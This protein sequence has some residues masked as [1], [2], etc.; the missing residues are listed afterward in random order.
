VDARCYC[1]RLG[2][3]RAERRLQGCLSGRPGCADRPVAGAAAGTGPYLESE[4]VT[5]CSADT[6]RSACSYAACG[7]TGHRSRLLAAATVAG[8][9][10][11]QSYA[12]QA[13]QRNGVDP[14][15]FQRQIQQESGFNPSAQSPAGAQG[16][17][18]FMPAT[19][20]GMGVDPSDPYASLDGAA[21][22]MKQHLDRYGATTAGHWQPTTRALATVDKYGGVP[23]VRAETQTYIKNILGGIGQAAGNVGQHSPRRSS[24]LPS[25]AEDWL[26]IAKEQLGKPY[27]WG[28]A[29]GRSTFD[30]N[31]PGFDCSGFVAYVMKK[32]FGVDLPA[33]TGSAY[34]STRPLEQGETPGSAGQ[35]AFY[36]MGQAG[37]AL[38]STSR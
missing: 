6:T 5:G 37:P 18:Q 21:R 15:I 32:A 20:Q 35:V 2:E 11:L 29:G 25:P 4:C 8:G 24:R 14:D 17:A 38:A 22:L 23:A 7:H 27:I 9:G 28:S 10:D 36:N 12:R 13:A 1:R 33:F 3:E 30:P 34:Q 26:A 16:I 31:A 19:A